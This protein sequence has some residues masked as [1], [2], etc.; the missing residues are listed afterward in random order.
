MQIPILS[1]LLLPECLKTFVERIAVA[2]FRVNTQTPL[3][4]PDHIIAIFESYTMNHFENY[5]SHTSCFKLF[6]NSTPSPQALRLCPFTRQQRIVPS[7]F[8][9][10]PLLQVGHSSPF[11]PVR[12]KNIVCFLL[13]CF[14]YFFCWSISSLFFSPTVHSFSPTV[15]SFISRAV[16]HSRV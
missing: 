2:S 6:T 3:R 5:S 12:S 4:R 1:L 15:H 7:Y 10:A 9:L 14:I 11:R 13:L 16:E 8:F